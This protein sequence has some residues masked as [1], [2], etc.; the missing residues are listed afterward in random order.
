MS[1]ELTIKDAIKDMFSNMTNDQKLVEFYVSKAWDKIVG[2]RIGS[3]T[4]NLRF[5][6]G[7]LFVSIGSA[8]LRS[9]LQFA[10]SKLIRLINSEIKKPVVTDIRFF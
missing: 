6:E 5:N 1:D 4:Q 8:A 7:I 3:E 10:K 2:E 9:E